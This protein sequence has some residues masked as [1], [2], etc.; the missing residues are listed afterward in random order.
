LRARGGTWN[1]DAFR[2]G[3]ERLPPADYLGMT[4]FE[5]W[6]A[7]MTAKLVATGDV[8]QAEIDSGRA[9]TGVP[10]ATPRVTAQDV[11]AMVLKRPS[12]RRNTSAVAL[13]KSGQRV[14]ARNIN[15]V[16]HTRVP[17]YVRGK[18]GV[19]VGDRGVFVFPD[20]NAHLLGEKPQHLYSVRFRARD[21]W[22]E[23][24]SRLDVVHLDMFED[25][26]ERA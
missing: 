17:R 23:A 22:G 11:P 5:R 3:V 15:P 7:W 18:A 21:L 9:A 24:A 12:V 14:R 1:L 19:V 10:R 6:L 2:H 4:Y 13:F 25:Y 16:G 20:T 26:L 8:T